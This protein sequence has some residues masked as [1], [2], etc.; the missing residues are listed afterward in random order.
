MQALLRELDSRS[1]VDVILTTG[2]TGLARR[3]VT[4]EAVAPL[5][6]RRLGGVEQAIT[7]AGLA[8]TPLAALS[9]LV[10]GVTERHR[11]IVAM[12]GSVNAVTVGV[13]LVE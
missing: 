1:D 12:A 6:H 10:C 7:A 9:R 11:L 4:P 8:K 3:D 5:L 2:G 13:G